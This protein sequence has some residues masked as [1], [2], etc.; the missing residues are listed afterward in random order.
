MLISPSPPPKM[1]IIQRHQR[2]LP[3]TIFYIAIVFLLVRIDFCSSNSIYKD[4]DQMDPLDNLKQLQQTHQIIFLQKDLNQTA[5]T[6]FQNEMETLEKYF[7][8]SNNQPGTNSILLGQED[9]IRSKVNEKRHMRIEDDLDF[10]SPNERILNLTTI[11]SLCMLL[12]LVLV[13]IYLI[14]SWSSRLVR[15]A[16]IQTKTADNHKQPYTISV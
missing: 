1:A 12:S 7:Q 6:I 11:I 9:E 3:S 2:F 10:P 13:T 5:K 16:L 8:F 4:N 15:R 14:N